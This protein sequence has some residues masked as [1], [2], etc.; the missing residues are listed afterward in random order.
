MENTLKEIKNRQFENLR[1][2]AEKTIRE[3]T[4]PAHAKMDGILQ[5]LQVHQIE[6]EMQNDE[7]R[8]ANEE[9]ELQRLKFEGIYDLAP[10][11]Y[12]IID[13]RGYI[14][15]VNTTGMNL[16]GASKSGIRRKSL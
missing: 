3:G 6:L 7:L 12:F 14:D 9:T 5:E 11:G 10:V 4:D 1:T 16:L 8:I 13:P 15:E 2:A